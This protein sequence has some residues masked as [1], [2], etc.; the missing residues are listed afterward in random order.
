MIAPMVIGGLL[1]VGQP[2]GH[3]D[4]WPLY[5][6]ANASLRFGDWPCA[7]P[8]TSGL[9]RRSRRRLATVRRLL[10]RL[11]G[12]ARARAAD[13]SAET[14]FTDEW[15]SVSPTGCPRNNPAWESRRL[16][17]LTTQ[18]NQLLRPL[19]RAA[20]FRARER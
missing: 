20:R 6:Q 4:S 8:G 5:I 18:H 15:S 12:E 11:D 7:A 13:Q 10:V 14:L 3:I 2:V 17:E 9:V 1:L 16:H 19:E